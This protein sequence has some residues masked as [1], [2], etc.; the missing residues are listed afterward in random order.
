MYELCCYSW[1]AH[2]VPAAGRT[3]ACGRWALTESDYLGRCPLRAE[4]AGVFKILGEMAKWA[5]N[6]EGKQIWS[7]HDEAVAGV[8]VF[9][10]PPFIL[11][12]EGKRTRVCSLLS[13]SF[14]PSATG[15]CLVILL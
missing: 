3:G 13:L 2:L 7:I 14:Q 6:S 15:H 9:A 5:N 12:E 8:D 11:H 10:F 4:G 1:N